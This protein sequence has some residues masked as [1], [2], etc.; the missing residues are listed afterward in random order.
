MAE[1]VVISAELAGVPSIFTL[2]TFL[3]IWRRAAARGRITFRERDQLLKKMAILCP[4][5]RFSIGKI[6]RE[7]DKKNL[8]SSSFVWANLMG[9]G[10]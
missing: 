8:S 10:I 2:R 9:K 4:T 3:A 6:S 5:R 1:W 7:K